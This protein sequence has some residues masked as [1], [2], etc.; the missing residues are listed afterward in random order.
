MTCSRVNIAG[1]YQHIVGV[2]P[3][4]RPPLDATA[5]LASACAPPPAP[6]PPKRGLNVVVRGIKVYMGCFFPCDYPLHFDLCG[7]GVGIGLV[8]VGLSLI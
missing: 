5:A 4:G 7:L 3:A 8:Q 6:P 1:N 2:G